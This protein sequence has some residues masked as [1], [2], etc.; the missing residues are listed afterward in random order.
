MMSKMCQT[1]YSKKS[2]NNKY[3]V[4]ISL[5]NIN[6]SDKIGIFEVGMS[7]FNE[8]YK[9]SSLVKP[10]VG[11]ITNISEA[12]LENFRGIKDIATAKSEIIYNIQKGGTIILNRD[13]KFFNFFIKIARKN[14]INVRS[15]GF[16]KESNVRFESIKKLYVIT[17]SI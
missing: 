16:S 9:L 2:F 5:F 4:P 3:G 12:H 6:E 13:D 7:K 14:K 11:I 1:C 17:N 15:F 10:H 8:I